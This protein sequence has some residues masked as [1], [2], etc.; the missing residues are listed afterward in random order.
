MAVSKEVW[1]CNHPPWRLSLYERKL[2]GI[3]CCWSLREILPTAKVQTESAGLR[4]IFHAQ[5]QLLLY[6]L[7]YTCYLQSKVF[8]KKSM[9]RKNLSQKRAEIQNYC[10]ALPQFFVCLFVCLFSFV[11]MTSIDWSVSHQSNFS[12]TSWTTN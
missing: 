1:K 3:I 4:A 8:R 2:P 9:K 5:I 12:L 10:S 11:K 6:L 7:T